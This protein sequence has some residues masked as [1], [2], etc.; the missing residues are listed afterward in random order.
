MQVDNRSHK[1]IFWKLI[2]WI[3]ISAGIVII[4][5]N[6]T[7]LIIITQSTLT[8]TKKNKIRIKVINKCKKNAK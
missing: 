5:V 6:S 2:N 4:N 7:C 3:N 1:Q 8:I